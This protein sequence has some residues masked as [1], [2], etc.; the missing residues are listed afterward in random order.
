VSRVW[1]FFLVWR[2]A[3][4]NPASLTVAASE[5]DVG[6][7]QRF[8]NVKSSGAD[9]LRSVLIYV[10]KNSGHILETRSAAAGARHDVAPRSNAMRELNPEQNHR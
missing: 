6:R 1:T 3:P 9:R 5:V 8:A 10:L 4:F 7:P 2:V